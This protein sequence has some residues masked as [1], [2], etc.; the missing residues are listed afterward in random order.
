MMLDQLIASLLGIFL[1][2]LAGLLPG[3][4]LTITMI[5]T[6]PLL[7]K[8]S[9][10]QCLIFYVCLAS[11]SQFAG[12]VTA[13]ITGVPGENNTFPLLSIRN[14]LI[15]SGKQVQALF[16]CAV[17]G[18]FGAITVF[19]FSW[20][21]IDVLAQHTAYLR[22]YVLIIASI[23]GII[24]TM[25]LSKNKIW[26]SIV[27]IVLAWILSRIGVDSRSGQDFLT[28]KNLYLSSG[29]PL[30]SVITGVY[31]IPKILE[32][33]QTK[34]H[35]TVPIVS[36]I[37]FKEKIELLKTNLTSGIRGSIIGFFS[38]L[39]P[40]IGID[41]SSY[42]AFNIEK[43]FN[44][45]NYISQLTASE[46]AQNGA[47]IGMLLPL[48]IFGVA[49]TASENVLLEAIGPSSAALNWTVV[50]PWFHYI[51]FWL[52]VTSVISFLLSWNFAL[53][54]MKVVTS[55]GKYAPF[56]FAVICVFAVAYIGMQYSLTL[57]YLIVLAVFSGIGYFFRQHDFLPFILIFLLQ[58]KLEPAMIRMY[59]IYL[60]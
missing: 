7:I 19:V 26:I 13:M 59:L 50:K 14:Q 3:I 21:I 39:I 1:G 25:M 57:Y 33:M 29:L 2:F 23:I 22:V 58:D 48:L 55:L 46:T 49:I 34:M 37:G 24:L 27:M 41:L 9:V 51:A 53:K 36:K 10:L 30:I 17:S 31:A 56:L 40:Y 28:F 60:S 54:I 35:I 45:E 32:S 8:F 15:D 6:F 42:L 44:K 47:I 43:Y 52:L 5:V 38:G 16:M 18:V 20:I 4:A 12:S 11:S